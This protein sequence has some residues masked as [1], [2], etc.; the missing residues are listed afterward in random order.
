MWVVLI[1]GCIPPIRPLIVRI[2]KS[3]APNMM[4]RSYPSSGTELRNYYAQNTGTNRGGM[5]VASQKSKPRTGTT[6][7]DN[8]SEE[9][10][11]KGDGTITKTTNVDVTYWHADGSEDMEDNRTNGVPHGFAR[12]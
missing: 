7:N 9:N 8:D 5:G 3:V 6:H 2:L 11:L 1:V 4:S 12:P 10:I